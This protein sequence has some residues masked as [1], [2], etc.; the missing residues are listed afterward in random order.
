MAIDNDTIFALG[1]LADYYTKAKN[2]TPVRAKV[3][4]ADLGIDNKSADELIVCINKYGVDK[5]RTR[6]A[7]YTKTEKVLQDDIPANELA[8][9]YMLINDEAVGDSYDFKEELVT[10]GIEDPEFVQS[11]QNLLTH[12][13]SFR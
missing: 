5:Y 7:A 12:D 9:D 2:P 1:Y 3:L 6:L 4:L 8:P 13:G 10:D 11:E